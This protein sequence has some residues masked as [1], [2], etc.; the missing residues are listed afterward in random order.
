MVSGIGNMSS[1]IINSSDLIIGGIYE[2]TAI[3][4]N[5]IQDIRN[6]PHVSWKNT[7]PSI[8]KEINKTAKAVANYS[9]EF[10]PLQDY[11]KSFTG[12]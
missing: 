7:R 6:R 5:W 10:S 8:F 11:D 9:A 3:P 1:G 4:T 2:L 12:R